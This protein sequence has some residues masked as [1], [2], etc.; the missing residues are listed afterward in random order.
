MVNLLLQVN[1]TGTFNKRFCVSLSQQFTQ[2][3]I[4]FFILF[5]ISR[6]IRE[7]VSDSDGSQLLLGPKHDSLKWNIQNEWPW[8]CL[9]D[10]HD[11]QTINVCM[12]NSYK[13]SVNSSKLLLTHCSIY[14]M[15]KM[16]YC[17]S[18]TIKWLVYDLS[19]VQQLKC[20][21]RHLVFS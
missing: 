14:R 20:L 6:L 19:L 21:F 5:F 11:A 16:N 1:P 3:Y 7:R 2:R 15:Q 4:I 12:S 9:T 13:T 18:L 10:A 8:H 17:L